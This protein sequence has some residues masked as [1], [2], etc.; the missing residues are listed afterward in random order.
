MKER[1]AAEPLSALAVSICIF[2]Y[3]L[4]CYLYLM[5][6]SIDIDTVLLQ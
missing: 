5:T 6:I 1:W 4:R 2:N 3:F